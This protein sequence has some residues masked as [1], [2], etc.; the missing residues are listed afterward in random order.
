MKVY[1][2][3]TGYTP[4]PAKMGAATEIVVEE[5]TKAFIKKNI[6]VSVVDI[7]AKERLKTDLP[8]VEVKIPKCF[9][10]TDMDILVLED[11]ILYKDEQP[12]WKDKEDWRKLYVLD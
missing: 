10:R 8:I 2:V 7:A 12:K 3:G 11:C 9:M 5:L 4:I 1:E 6:D